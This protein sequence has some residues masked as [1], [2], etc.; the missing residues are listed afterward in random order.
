MAAVDLDRQAIERKDFPIG[1]R[2]YDTA[3]VDAHLQALAGEFEALQRE[4]SGTAESSLAA[5]AGSQV[6]S[7]IQA[8]EKAASEIERQALENGRAVREEAER[9]AER[10]RQDAIDTARAHVAAV[11]KVAATLLERVRA[12]DGQVGALMESLRAGSGRL[13]GDL[14]AV[15]SGMA[16]LYDAAAGRSVSGEQESEPP[17]SPPETAAPDIHV[18][19]DSPSPAPATAPAAP[20]VPEAPAPAAAGTSAPAPASTDV[21]G[22]RL[23]ALNMALNGESRADTE[24]YLAENFELPDRDKLVDEVYAAI[25]G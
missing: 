13:S 8:A 9:D 21:D 24:R 1:R 16:D 5:A 25:E 3:A 11:S 14:A 23:V 4:L 10:T 18:D 15:E 6:Q 2:G 7:I 22:A 12:M 20:P 19:P 17:L